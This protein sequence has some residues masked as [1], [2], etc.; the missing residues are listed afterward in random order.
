M[1]IKG[2]LTSDR[3]KPAKRSLLPLHGEGREGTA[4]TQSCDK[5]QFEL[6]TESTWILL[7]CPLGSTKHRPRLCTVSSCSSRFDSKPWLRID[8][9][10]KLWRKNWTRKG[11]EMSCFG[12]AAGGQTQSVSLGDVTKAAAAGEATKVPNN[13]GTR[14][15]GLLCG[16]W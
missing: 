3:G 16:C 15:I 5:S 1:H 9:N 8:H 12:A 14:V 6:E 4:V 11:A 7:T 13:P 2:D 10:L